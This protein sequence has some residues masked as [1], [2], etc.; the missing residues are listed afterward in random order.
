MVDIVSLQDL[1]DAVSDDDFS[2]GL[3]Q[4]NGTT[5]VKGYKR[6]TFKKAVLTAA[7]MDESNPNEANIRSLNDDDYAPAE[8]V[9]PISHVLMTEDPVVASDGF[10][11]EHV[12]IDAWVRK[13]QAEVVA[14]KEQIARGNDSKQARAILDRGVLSPLTHLKLSH[15]KLTPNRNVRVMARDFASSGSSKSFS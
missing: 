8:L 10:T 11:Y 5:G 15:L 14:A 3:Q 4:G 1:A 13:Q 2:I 7:S 12:A 9:C 6:T